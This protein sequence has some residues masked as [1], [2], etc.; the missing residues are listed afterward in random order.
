MKSETS[1]DILPV[2][3]MNSLWLRWTLVNGKECQV[4]QQNCQEELEDRTDAASAPIEKHIH[5]CHTGTP[6]R[7][8]A[9][10]PNHRGPLSPNRADDDCTQRANKLVCFENV[11]CSRFD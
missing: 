11:D 4:E 6:V 9:E 8:V 3:S 5:Q 10:W 1:A 2:A 7:S